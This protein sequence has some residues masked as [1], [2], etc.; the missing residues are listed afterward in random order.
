MN[1]SSSF[2]LADACGEGGWR[3]RLLGRCR[4]GQANGTEKHE[5]DVRAGF[6]NGSRRPPDGWLASSVDERDQTPVPKRFPRIVDQI[7]PNGH[8]TVTVS[9]L[10]SRG[11]P[12]RMSR[13]MAVAVAAAVALQ[14]PAGAQ[15]PVPQYRIQPLTDLTGAPALSL[16]LRKLTTIGTVVHMTAHPDDENNAGAG[17]LRPPRRGAGGAR[18]GD[19]RRRRTE[20]DRHR[21][22]RRAGRPPHRGTAD[23]AS[24]RWRRAVLHAR[25]GLWL[26][27]QP[28][29]NA[30]EV[31]PSGDPRR[32][33]A[34][35]PDPAARRHRDDEP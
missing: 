13:F 5:R 23:R 34:P 31:G 35:H 12:M 28:G 3:G 33:R 1:A 16:A 29:G 26:L 6:G 25:G 19:A 14:W 7:R 21:A 17:A 2:G 24:L 27:V 11:D 8:D 15:Q 20:R 4:G 32:L 10:P 9:N 18:D 22:L 30:R